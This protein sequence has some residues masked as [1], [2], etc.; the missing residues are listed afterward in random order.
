MILLTGSRNKTSIDNPLN[1]LE[2]TNQ[3]SSIQLQEASDDYLRQRRN[4]LDSLLS[5]C[6]LHGIEPPAAD[7]VELEAVVEELRRRNIS[8]N[9]S[10]PKTWMSWLGTEIDGC[11]LTGLLAEGRFSFLFKA[12]SKTGEQCVF[13]I[14]RAPE[15]VFQ[16][17]QCSTQALKVIPFQTGPVSPKPDEMV[18]LQIE[19]LQ[20]LSS[21]LVIPVITSGTIE[22]RYYYSMPL[23]SGSTM[24]QKLAQGGLSIEEVLTLFHALSFYM[25]TVTLNSESTNFTAAGKYHGDITPDNIYLEYHPEDGHM[26]GLTLIDPG[27]FGPLDCKEGFFE[28]CMI[29]TPSYSPLLE[30]DDLLAVGICL[31]EALTGINPFIP[32]SA[33]VTRQVPESE[34][35][36]TLTPIALEQDVLDLIN[37]KES[38]LQPYLTPL[39]N[40]VRPSELRPELPLDL[41]ALLIKALRLRLTN[42]GSLALAEGFTSFTEL[43]TW[44]EQAIG[45]CR[46]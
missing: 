5:G 10:K 41:E 33:P 35:V 30:A 24:R 28:T 29:S 17:E 4:A 37:F 45:Q 34:E 20:E 44:L 25:E 8:Y 13:K 18:R 19:R 11:M 39:K 42:T 22:D 26:T 43:R 14:A 6:S 46:N 23:L 21:P 32:R 16:D 12:E 40:L 31:W 27:Y 3:L 15:D 1:M 38:L 2:S 9:E 36:I 7:V